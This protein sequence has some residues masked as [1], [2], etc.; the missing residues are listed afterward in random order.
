MIT[1]EIPLHITIPRSKKKDK[2][3]S[4]TRNVWDNLHWGFKTTVKS[5]IETL[6]VPQISEA[7]PIEGSVQAKYELWVSRED[8]DLANWCDVA[9]KIL[10]DIVVRNQLIPDD[11]VKYVVKEERLYMGLD[12]KNPRVRISWSKYDGVH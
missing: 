11:C 7:L 4:L 9:G 6:A 3:I 8:S 2:K 12:K 5:M 1:I 10:Q